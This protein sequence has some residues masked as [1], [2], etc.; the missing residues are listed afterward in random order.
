M[1]RAAIARAYRF[2]GRRHDIGVRVPRGDEQ[3]GHT[4]N[5]VDIT[6]LGRQ[7]EWEDSPQGYPQTAPYVWWDYHDRYGVAPIA[8]SNPTDAQR[9]SFGR[10]PQTLLERLLGLAFFDAARAVSGSS[11]SSRRRA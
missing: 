10:I 8:S 5:Y 3:A 1:P 2:E 11:P 4:W 6:A 9:G 7:E